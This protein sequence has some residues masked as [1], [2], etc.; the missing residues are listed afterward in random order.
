M[1]LEHVA[2]L[3]PSVLADLGVV[4]A[5]G[6]VVVDRGHEERRAEP[7]GRLGRRC[8]V[9][10]AVQ[11]RRLEAQPGLFGGLAHR[12]PPGC[13]LEPGVGVV[14]ALLLVAGSSWSAGSI[15]PPG[16]THMP[17]AKARSRSRRS[18]RTSTPSVRSRAT[19][20]VAAGI[21]P[22]SQSGPPGEPGRG[23]AVVPTVS[24]LPGVGA[25]HAGASERGSGSIGART[26]T[27]GRPTA[28]AQR[29][30]GILLRRCSY[31]AVITRSTP[32]VGADGAEDPQMWWSSVRGAGRWPVG[33]HA[34]A[35]RT[36][37]RDRER[38]EHGGAFGGCSRGRS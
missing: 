25:G 7:P 16:N 26:A 32:D 4:D 37:A 23:V 2:G 36:T 13:T 33:Q 22:G 19:T 30:L 31:S 27:Q 21:A 8:P 15:R 1:Q 20:T 6:V 35:T 29:V 28:H 14:V 18:M 17:P 12:G 9:R 5:H 38:G 11:R 10:P 24:T 3:L 34:T